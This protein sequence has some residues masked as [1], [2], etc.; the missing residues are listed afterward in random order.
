MLQ[1]WLAKISIY[2][3]IIFNRLKTN[4]NQSYYFE[5]IK[6]SFSSHFIILPITFTQ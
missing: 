3:M 2:D 4:L 1:T 5:P 6:K